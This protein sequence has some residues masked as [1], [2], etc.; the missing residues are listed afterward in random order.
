M[1]AKVLA[2]PMETTRAGLVR[3]GSILKKTRIENGWS[4]D[5]LIKYLH[6]VTGK[7]LSKSTISNLERGNQEPDWV[8]ISTL[9]HGC[10]LKNEKGVLYKEQDLFEIACERYPYKEAQRKIFKEV[11]T[12]Y[13]QAS[14]H[15]GCHSVDDCHS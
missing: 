7:K 2:P 15:G 11:T 5:E 10:F 3:L 6:E 13:G 14:C 9:V 4:M 1:H 8:T 12:A